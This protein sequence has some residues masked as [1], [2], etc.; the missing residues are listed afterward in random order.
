MFMCEIKYILIN[1][2]QGFRFCRNFVSLL[3]SCTIWAMQSCITLSQVVLFI[4]ATALQSVGSTLTKIDK[5][6]YL[7][8][9]M[10]NQMFLEKWDSWE[11]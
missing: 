1:Y 4:N 9:F 8:V 2:T 11:V 6:H 3:L 5:Q 7:V 10:V